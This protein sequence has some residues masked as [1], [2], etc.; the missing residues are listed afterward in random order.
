ML[1]PTAG[2]HWRAKA[3]DHAMRQNEPKRLRNSES[4]P[5]GLAMLGG[6][7]SALGWPTW[8]FGKTN[9]SCADRLSSQPL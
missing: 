4:Q 6:R 1:R 7:A 3:P 9:H 2:Y 8:F 5:I